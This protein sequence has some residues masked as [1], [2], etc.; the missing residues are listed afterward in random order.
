MKTLQM[1]L[2][3]IQ[4][5]LSRS[6]MKNIMGGFDLSENETG[7]SCQDTVCKTDADCCTADPICSPIP[8]WGGKKAC[9]H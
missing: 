3:N 4:G 2:E 8:N 6:E 1:N 9:Y 5:K 7:G